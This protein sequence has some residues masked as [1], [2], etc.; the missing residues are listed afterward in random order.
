MSHATQLRDAVK[1][2]FY[3]FALERGFVRGKASSLFV[4]FR[5]TIGNKVQVFE[6]Q[7]D[8]SHRPRFVVNFGEAPSNGCEHLGKHISAEFLEPQHCPDN[9]R[10]QRWRGGSMRTWFQISKPWAETLCTLR[11][12]YTPEEVTGQLIAA[13]A[14][15]ECWWGTKHEGPHVCVWHSLSGREDSAAKASACAAS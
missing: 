6:L 7:W 9:G 13:F 4:P 15:L 12:S 11:W 8:K 5:R 14:E 2:T 1:T 10:L 3:P